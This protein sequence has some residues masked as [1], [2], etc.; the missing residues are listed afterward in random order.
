VFW[1][2][3]DVA[4]RCI[5][6]NVRKLQAVRVWPWWRLMLRLSPLLN[7]HRTEEEL[8]ARTVIEWLWARPVLIAIVLASAVAHGVISHHSDSFSS[9][10]VWLIDAG[11]SRESAQ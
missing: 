8:K 4:I 2:V 5:Q 6:R 10:F 9:L 7:V 3:Q 11:G 1:Q